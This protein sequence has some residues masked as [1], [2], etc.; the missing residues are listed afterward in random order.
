MTMVS[1][2]FHQEHQTGIL[3]LLVHYRLPGLILFS[4]IRSA[5]PG[6]CDWP[7]DTQNISQPPPPRT[8]LSSHRL[9]RNTISYPPTTAPCAEW[10]QASAFHPLPVLL[11]WCSTI[12]KGEL[13]IRIL[14]RH[15][16]PNN[17]YERHVRI[18]KSINAAH[19][20]LPVRALQREALQSRIGES[21]LWVRCE[22]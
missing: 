16:C 6:R 9:V 5:S 14:T 12:W 1:V 21:R 4:Q 3:A 2:M 13:S 11:S 18:C 10:C 19:L 15:S 8:P 7:D 17:A 20:K 22:T